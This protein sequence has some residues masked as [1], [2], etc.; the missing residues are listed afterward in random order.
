MGTG[1]RS[2]DSIASLLLTTRLG[3]AVPAPLSPSRYW[4][5]L[6]SVPEPAVLLGLAADDLA[7][8]AGLSHD[9][10][11]QVERL[12]AGTTNLAF[13]LER[14]ERQG[15]VPL[16][17]FDEG[18]PARLRERLADQAPPVLFAVGDRALLST[19]G[20][21][22]VGSRSVTQ[23]GAEVSRAVAE[24]AAA[25]G[26]TV[27]SGG[28]KGVDQAAMSAAHSAGGRVVAYL[29]DSLQRRVREPETRRAVAEG[30]VCLATPYGPSAGFSAANAIGRNK[31]IYASARMTLVVAGDLERG[32]TW[33]GATEALRRGSGTVAVWVG[34]GAGPGNARMVER[35]AIPVS[36]LAAVFAAPRAPAAPAGSDQLRFG[37]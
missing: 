17:A 13:A 16:T 36:D 5:L 32:G 27:I 12:L 23:E 21:G 15:F 30:S 19:D 22:I 11:L 37:L 10:L 18:Y 9:D 24:R 3:D 25:E 35:G 6:D 4:R 31:L 1:A 26:L 7:R 33:A 2:E 28:A 8:R 29:A 34:P 14:L 20:I